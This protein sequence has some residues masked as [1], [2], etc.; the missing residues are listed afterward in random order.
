MFVRLILFAIKS[1]CEKSRFLDPL[2]EKLGMRV[3]AAVFHWL[4]A[5][6]RILR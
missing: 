2:G 5:V 1:L 3:E 6:P 4:A